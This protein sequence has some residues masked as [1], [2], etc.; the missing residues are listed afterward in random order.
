MTEENQTR[1]TAVCSACGHTW[2]VRNPE[3]TANRKCSR[4]GSVDISVSAAEPSAEPKT[5]GEV[6][7]AELAAELTRPPELPEQPEP[8]DTD[9]TFILPDGS[10]VAF[11]VVGEPEP[12]KHRPRIPVPKINPI[13]CI[14]GLG[15][16]TGVGALL[17]FRRK[18]KKPHKNHTQPAT[19]EKEEQTRADR[20]IIGH[21]SMDGA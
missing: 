2:T 20:P 19:A 14:I 15:I 5:S 18:N 17:I 13:L 16:L 3:P 8:D 12:E 9:E 7:I 10:G 21:Y 1:T 4:C 6:N 11:G